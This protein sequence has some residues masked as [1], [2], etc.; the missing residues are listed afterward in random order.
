MKPYLKRPLT[1]GGIF[2]M[3]VV[4]IMIINTFYYNENTNYEPQIFTSPITKIKV[5]KHTRKLYLLSDDAIVKEYPIDLGFN[6]LGPKTREGDGK[7][8]EGIYQISSRNPN[9][10][11]YL[12]LRISYPNQQDISQA[13]ANGVSA[14]SDI[15]IHGLPNFTS[16]L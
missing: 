4:G 10:K 8:P 5:V 9:S 3:L 7:T 6:P 12:S 2:I 15:M 1:A 11:F 16:F 14:G 13:Q